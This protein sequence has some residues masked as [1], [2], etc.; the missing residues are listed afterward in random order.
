VPICLLAAAEDCDV[1]DGLARA[2]RKAVTSS[3]L[4]RPVVRPRSSRSVR[5]PRMVD[6]GFFG[7]SEESV[8][9]E[10]EVCPVA[11]LFTEAFVLV[12]NDDTEEAV[13][14]VE[15]DCG[16]VTSFFELLRLV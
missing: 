6:S 10:I 9:D 16:V 14:V 15:A 11:R 7:A 4:I 1:V 5:E 3:A 13:P 2:V 8:A 12:G